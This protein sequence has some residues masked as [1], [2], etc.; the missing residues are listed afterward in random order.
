MAPP[1]VSP[2]AADTGHSLAGPLH[3]GIRRCCCGIRRCLWADRVLLGCGRSPPC[4][5][6]FALLALCLFTLAL[7]RGL[8]GAL[9]DLAAPLFGWRRAERR[10]RRRFRSSLAD[11]RDVRR[12]R[13]LLALLRLV[14]DLR[15]L[16]E[17]LVALS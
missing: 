2:R 5:F 14:L 7:G 17:G 6:P 11:E 3:V 1:T 16:G 12:L 8:W 15:A 10:S 4:E 13:A 9:G